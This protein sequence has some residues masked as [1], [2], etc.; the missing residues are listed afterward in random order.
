MEER[1]QVREQKLV[2]SMDKAERE[3]GRF[4]EMR[5]EILSS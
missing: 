1:L 5:K 2:K 4:E 3:G